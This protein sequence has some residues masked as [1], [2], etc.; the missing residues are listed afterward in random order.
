M[1][2][3][4]LVAALRMVMQLV[5][6][7]FVLRAVFATGSGMITFSLI[8]VMTAVAARE[9][10][11]R[12]ARRLAGWS[13]HFV[14]AA[15]VGGATALA[16]LL[17]LTTALRPSPWWDPRYAIP[18]AGIILGG[19]LNA[20]SL[21]LDSVLGGV[22]AAR[23]GIEAQLA[24]GAPFRSATQALVNDAIRRGLVPALNQMAAA[25]VVTLPGTMTGQ[26]LAGLDPVEAVKYQILLMLLLSGAAGLAAGMAAILAIRRLT[27]GRDR[28]RLDRLTR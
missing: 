4:I 6:I 10:A 15:A 18:V 26:I 22:A 12:P 14:S 17:A 23:Q 20:A 27:D 3:A 24:L 5:L 1:H 9:A 19:A 8:I 21:A 25:G 11:V 2:R 28:L 13:N 16:A 7:G